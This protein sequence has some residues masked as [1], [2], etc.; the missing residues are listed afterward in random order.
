MNDK[1]AGERVYAGAGVY[2]LIETVMLSVKSG[3]QRFCSHV[4]LCL[5]L[6]YLTVSLKKKFSAMVCVVLVVL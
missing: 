3:K 4:H 2:S 1:T 5:H 6:L